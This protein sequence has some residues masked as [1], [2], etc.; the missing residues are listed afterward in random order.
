MKNPIVIA[1][2]FTVL[3]SIVIFVLFTLLGFME[4]RG[5]AEA[6]T[7][8]DKPLATTSQEPTA[9]PDSPVEYE[10]FDWAL[11]CP[12]LVDSDYLKKFTERESR[13]K[14]EKKAIQFAEERTRPR[15]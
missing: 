11:E 6:R 2:T 10:V 1:A 15:R 14:S 5:L 9:L 7:Y 3:V 4:R 13:R 12:E 8:K